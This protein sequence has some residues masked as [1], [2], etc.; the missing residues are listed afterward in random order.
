MEQQ[1]N[2]CKVK[3]TSPIIF[4][5]VVICFM[6]LGQLVS[7]PILILMPQG[8][9]QGLLFGLVNIVFFLLPI[10]LIAKKQ[11]TLPLKSLFRLEQK[12][13]VRT[14]FEAIWGTAGIVLFG[15]ALTSIIFTFLPAN[16]SEWLLNIYKVMGE[17][18]EQLFAV[19]LNS[20]IIL[21]LISAGVLAPVYEELVFRGYLQKNLESRM[22]P[23][24][25]I[26]LVAVLFAVIHFNFIATLQLLLLA[27]FLG[28]VAYKTNSILVPI[29]CHAANNIYSIVAMNYNKHFNIA[30]DF[31]L[32]K[33]YVSFFLI[34]GIVA[35]LFSFRYFIN[36]EKLGNKK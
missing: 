6:I 21:P 9:F 4:F 27:L 8:P 33:E 30:E 32:P 12:V 34:L 18:Y 25:A 35:I 10:I 13:C 28:Y 7:L 15:T 17:T 1:I 5:V 26:I 31:L 3:Q 19:G 36:L 14:Y 16:V 20:W 23:S 22:K 24:T 2:S 29:I 11:K